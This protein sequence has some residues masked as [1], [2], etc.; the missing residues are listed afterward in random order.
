MI[1]PKEIKDKLRERYKESMV[2]YHDNK[3]LFNAFSMIRY[4]L[5]KGETNK[6]GLLEF[7]KYNDEVDQ[8]R[9]ENLL[10]AIPELKEVYEWAKS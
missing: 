9:K 6:D 7:I 8:D 2:R 3:D 5:R 4:T 1:L 10:E